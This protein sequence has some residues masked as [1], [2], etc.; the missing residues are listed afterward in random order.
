MWEIWVR[1]LGWEDPLEKGLA[2]HSNILA[3][4]IPMDRGAWQSMG[5]GTTKQLSTTQH[6][7][8]REVLAYF[9]LKVYL[10]IYLAALGLSGVILDLCWCVQ[11]L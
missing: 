9:F 10:F 5:L 4:K 6:S 1:S 7:A 8:T 2:T 3:W 11:H